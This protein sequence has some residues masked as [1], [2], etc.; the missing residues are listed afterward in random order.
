[1]KYKDE[2]SGLVSRRRRVVLEAA[3]GLFAERTIEEVNM[4]DIAAAADMGVA[5]LYRYFGTKLQL[6]IELAALKW[7][8][9]GAEL[10][11]RHDE[12]AAQ[13]PTAAAELDLFL[14]SYL[15]LYQEHPQLLRFNANFD[16]YIRHEN[17]TPGQTAPYS[18]S[19][20]FFAR[21]LESIY[22]RGLRDGT[23]RADISR[24]ELYALVTYT[25]LLSARKFAC[26]AQLLDAPLQG[27]Q[28][29]HLQK[30][31]LLDYL[32]RA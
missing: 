10:A 20:R 28:V 19:V 4:T 8:Q 5:S 15:T 7:Q 11:G 1:M 2:I 32:T 3:F 23:L 25:L 29:M 18:E 13:A 12:W 31:M 21:D 9:Y 14:E 6:V 16:L 27:E 30:Q 24:Q 22:E 17:A 26:G